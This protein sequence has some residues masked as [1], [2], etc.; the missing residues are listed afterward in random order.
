MLHLNRTARV[1]LIAWAL[2]CFALLAQAQGPRPSRIVFLVLD[3]VGADTLAQVSTPNIDALAANGAVFN[4]AYAHPLCKASRDSLLR[5]MRG[6]ITRG[7]SCAGVD[8]DSLPTTTDTFVR[9]LRDEAGYLT[10]LVGKWH[11][12]RVA[13]EGMPWWHA[14]HALGFDH[15]WAGS[16]TSSIGGCN[17]TGNAHDD[18]VF[19]SSSTHET[20][21]QLD[22]LRDLIDQADALGRPLF[23]WVGL[24]DA[25]SPWRQ[26]PNHMMPAGYSQPLP[27]TNR[28][29]YESEV[30][31]LDWLVGKV[32]A[33][34]PPDAWLF[35]FSENGT[36]VAVTEP[37]TTRAKLTTYERGVHVPLII[38]GGG[39]LPQVIDEPVQLYDLPATLLAGM[40]LTGPGRGEGRNLFGTPQACAPFAFVRRDGN[41]HRAVIEQR[42][43]LH[44]LAG[45]LE[46]YD[47]LTDPEETTPLPHTGADF[48]RL[49]TILQAMP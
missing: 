19:Y 35:V 32:V 17:P 9:T 31:A 6:G 41:G 36:P 1:A 33:L 22:A 21:R 15:W 5:G 2:A 30:L 40:Q 8:D 37:P 16:A 42:H 49:L 3:D 20:Q 11:V 24:T 38:S 27:P 39:L 47:L 26:P 18:G 46:F 28:T 13:S 45:V 7:E 10:G 34:L 44:D 43:K 25:H 4:R 12:G 29:L 48:V 14:P 23:A